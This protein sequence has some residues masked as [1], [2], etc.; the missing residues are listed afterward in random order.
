MSIIIGCA[1][2]YGAFYIYQ[3]ILEWE[4][5][6]GTKRMHWMIYMAYELLG[7]IGVSALVA[8]VG[9]FFFYHAYR[10]YGKLKG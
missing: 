10:L 6:G 3:D 7:A 2:L 9:L 5:M 8:I 1:M 4:A